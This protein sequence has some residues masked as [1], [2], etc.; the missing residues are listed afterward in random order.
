MSAL[1]GPA[2][3]KMVL[4]GIS[5][6]WNSHAYIIGQPRWTVQHCAKVVSSCGVPI[7]CLTPALQGRDVTPD[8]VKDAILQLTVT[9]H[10]YT[11]VQ[12]LVTLLCEFNGI[13]VKVCM[14]LTS[15]L[16]TSMFFRCLARVALAICRATVLESCL[17]ALCTTCADPW[18]C[19]AGAVGMAYEA[20]GTGCVLQDHEGGSWLVH[21]Q[22]CLQLALWLT[23]HGCRHTSCGGA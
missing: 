6:T 23:V 21:G 1:D 20:Y 12:D 14:L 16:E 4:F 2:R 18:S 19:G 7:L 8:D 3:V 11:G 17:F 10:Y 22:V 13:T 5:Q 9:E 15:S